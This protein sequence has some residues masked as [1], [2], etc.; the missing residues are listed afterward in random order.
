MLSLEILTILEFVD[1]HFLHLVI[2]HG[3]FFKLMT[4]ILDQL[5]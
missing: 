3:P 5:V 2:Q 4:K 1:S